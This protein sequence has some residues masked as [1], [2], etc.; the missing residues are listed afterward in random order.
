MLRTTFQALLLNRY[1]AIHTTLIL[2]Y[3]KI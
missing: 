1:N 3:F 2:E